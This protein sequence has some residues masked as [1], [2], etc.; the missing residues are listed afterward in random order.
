MAVFEGAARG[1]GIVKIPGVDTII[2]EVFRVITCQIGGAQMLTFSPPPVVGALLHVAKTKVGRVHFF[3][4][5]VC[6]I[7][8]RRCGHH[9]SSRL[10]RGGR[11][12]TGEARVSALDGW[13]R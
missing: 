5:K 2:R 10:R 12:R 6:D 7:S 13:I 8:S 4:T 9:H 11:C 1:G 3:Y